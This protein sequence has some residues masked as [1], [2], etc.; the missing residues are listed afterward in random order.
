MHSNHFEDS[1][2]DDNDVG[3]DDH[4]GD[5]NDDDSYDDNDDYDVIAESPYAHWQANAGDDVDHEDG[6]NIEH[7]DDDNIEHEDDYNNGI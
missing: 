3:Y 6:D 2:N 1:V 7:E 4:E 5:N